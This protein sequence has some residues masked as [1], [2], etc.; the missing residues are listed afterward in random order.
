M[1]H[2][3][4]N[5]QHQD[6]FK[7]HRSDVKWKNEFIEISENLKKIFDSE[8]KNIM[9]TLGALE[10]ALEMPLDTENQNELIIPSGLEPGRKICKTRL[11]LKLKDQP[12]CERYD[13]KEKIPSKYEQL[14]KN[15]YRPH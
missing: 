15:S 14:Y 5:M 2:G 7:N 11:L 1:T 3:L 10:I 4:G 8:K 6:E 13:S 12:E 9:P